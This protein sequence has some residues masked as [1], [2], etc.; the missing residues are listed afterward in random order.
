M[1][2]S[3]GSTLGPLLFLLYIN[4]LRFSLNKAV[5]NHFTDDTCITYASRKMKTLE[6]DLNHEL[7]LASDW[8]KANRLSLNVYKSKLIIFKSKQK[9]G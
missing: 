4:D 5:A 8:L 6:T 3:S 1:R 9:K 2:G 7:K